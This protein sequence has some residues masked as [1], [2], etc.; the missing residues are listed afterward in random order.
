MG[1][2]TDFSYVRRTKKRK[3]LGELFSRKSPF[4]FFYYC[5]LDIVGKIVITIVPTNTYSTKSLKWC[6]TFVPTKFAHSL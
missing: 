5:V 4:D 2:S 6:K 3:L 1:K